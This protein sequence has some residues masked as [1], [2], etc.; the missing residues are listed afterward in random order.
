MGSQSL[1]VETHGILSTMFVNKSLRR[2]YATG[3]TSLRALQHSEERTSSRLNPSTG[4]FLS[5]SYVKCG[6]WLAKTKD[7]VALTARVTR[8][9][10]SHAPIGEYYERFNI[11]APHACRCGQF[12]T[13]KHLLQYCEECSDRSYQRMPVYYDSLIK[14]LK[15]NPWMFAFADRP[16]PKADG[17]PALAA[18]GEGV[19]EGGV[20]SLVGTR[21][22]SAEA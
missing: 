16:E 22:G 18:E 1:W 3:R 21:G 17:T 14:F 12:Q 2:L 19:E 6:T 7:D 4:G 9:I 20:G 11:D 8:C 5:P 10:L 13:R 15:A